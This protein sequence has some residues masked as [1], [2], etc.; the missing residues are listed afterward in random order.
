MAGKDE[1]YAE[2]VLVRLS[3]AKEEGRTASR[4]P[5]WI[6]AVAIVCT[7]WNRDS[8][9]MP[10][11]GERLWRVSLQIAMIIMTVTECHQHP[12]LSGV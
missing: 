7:G 3:L 8:S 6:P 5:Q 1:V 11:E 10:T 4:D 2:P 12:S 9:E